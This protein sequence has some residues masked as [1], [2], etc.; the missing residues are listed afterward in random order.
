MNGSPYSYANLSCAEACYAAP[1]REEE[2][3]PQEPSRGPEP[4]LLEQPPQLQV[5]TIP[6]ARISPAFA[7]QGPRLLTISEEG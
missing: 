4:V 1:S 5:S 2:T 6:T 7:M 3:E